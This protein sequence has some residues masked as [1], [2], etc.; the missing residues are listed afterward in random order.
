MT[1]QRRRLFVRVFPL[2]ELE[3]RLNALEDREPMVEFTFPMDGE[4]VV[5]GTWDVDY[6]KEP[7]ETEPAGFAD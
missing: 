3:A 1:R 6:G 2:H 5:I 7:E 4:V